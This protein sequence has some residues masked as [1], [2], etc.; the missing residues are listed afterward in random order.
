MKNV[1]ILL[2]GKILQ[3]TVDFFIKKLSNP[4][5]SNINLGGLYY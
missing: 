3:E 5:C 2:Q 4:E 1:T